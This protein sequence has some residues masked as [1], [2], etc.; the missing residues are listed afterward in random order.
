VEWYDT[1]VLD[2]KVGE[3]LAMARKTKN[4]DWYIGAM[5]DWTERS[6]SLNLSFLEA[7]DYQVEIFEDGINANNA[8]MD[9]KRLQ[10]TVTSKTVF[11][12]NLA[13]GGGWVAKISKAR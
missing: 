11:V 7:G 12:A 9:Y 3:H 4:G 8:A 6:L 10:Q 1:K 2:A 5:N 13:K